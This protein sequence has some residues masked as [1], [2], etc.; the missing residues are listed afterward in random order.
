MD[1]NIGRCLGETSLLEV[2]FIS[3]EMPKVGEYVSLKYEDKNVLG[4]IESLV[5]GSVAI[6]DDISDPDTIATIK[7]FEGD[8][9]YIKGKIRILGDFNDNLTIPR[10]P[11]P[12]GTEINLADLK[13][14]NQIFEVK[15]GLKI[16]KLINQADVEVNVDINNMVSRH[17]AILAMTGAGKSNTVAVVVDELLKYNGCIFIFDMHSEYINTDFKN[18]NVNLIEAKINP[19]YMSFSEIKK[20]AKIPDNAYIQ[21]RYFREAHKNVLERAKNGEIIRDQF[22]E[23][24][25][26]LLEKWAEG[27]DFKGQSV[28]RDKKTI[29]DVLNKIDDFESR[30]GNILDLSTGNILSKVKLGEVNVLDLGS[31]DETAAEILVAHVLRNALDQKKKNIKKNDNDDDK[32]LKFPV[33]FVLEEAHILAPDNRNTKSKYWISRI[34]REGRKFGLGLCMVSQSPKSLDKN[35]LSQANNMIILRLVEPKDQRHVQEA[36]ESLSKDLMD[37]LPSLNKGEAIIIG[38]MTKIPTLVKIDKFDGNLGGEDI[39][40]VNV[41]KNSFEDEEKA[42][43]EEED[44]HNDLEEEY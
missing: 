7:E 18:G 31:V 6:H 15:N 32:K 5:R 22:I 29:I 21:E 23:S 33:F 40:I 3:K 41:W 13:D 12:P 20:L 38:L 17:L 8:D 27:E 43:K 11:A 1:N 34:A 10:T 44:E 2:N 30:Y 42:L 25:K 28:T 9:H 19:I 4:M 26:N 24:M 16:G 36:S 39:D 14:L 37:Q 35:S